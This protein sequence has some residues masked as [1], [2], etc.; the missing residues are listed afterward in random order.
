MLVPF[1]EKIIKVLYITYLGRYGVQSYINPKTILG[2][3]ADVQRS[4]SIFS[5][6]TVASMAS[7]TS[8]S[9]IVLIT[10]A[11]QGLGFEMARQLASN[12]PGY[13][14]LIGSRDPDKGSAAVTKLKEQGLLSV[15]SVTIDVS[16]DKSIQAAANGVASK[17]GRLD[18]LINNAGISPEGH[19]P[20]DTPVREVWRTAF[21]VNTCGAFLVTEAFVP[22][23]KKSS[24]FPPYRVCVDLAG[25]LHGTTRSE[26]YIR[27][28]F[29][30]RVPE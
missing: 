15:E 14:I 2:H 18:V 23:L 11:N 24:T 28:S 13:H 19:L 5:S 26:R 20:K 4:M 25:F 1:V 21:D 17:F 10:G 3:L 16:D 30:P 22:L 12:H 6:T 9:T 7:T 8:T 29:G 27:R